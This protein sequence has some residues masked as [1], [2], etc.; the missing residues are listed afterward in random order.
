M[1]YG[2]HH[3]SWQPT[4]DYMSV[5]FVYDCPSGKR[6]YA[7]RT[8]AKKVLKRIGRKYQFRTEQ[9]VYECQLCGG[10]W[11]LTSQEQSSGKA[12]QTR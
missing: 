2:G 6:G 4:T 5:P 11:H 9:A 3:T 7:T 12:R 10:L 1:S 8:A